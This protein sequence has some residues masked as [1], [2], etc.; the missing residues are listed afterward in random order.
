MAI[1][2]LGKKKWSEDKALKQNGCENRQRKWAYAQLHFT[3]VLIFVSVTFELAEGEHPL[4][5]TEGDCV[6]TFYLYQLSTGTHLSTNPSEGEEHSS[7]E[8]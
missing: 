2:V 8:D 6:T 3:V 1:T 7:K 4:P 5:K